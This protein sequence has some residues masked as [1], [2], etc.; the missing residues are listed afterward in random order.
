MYRGTTPTLIFNLSSNP[1]LDLSEVAEVW[2]TLKY[3]TYTKTWERAECSIDTEHKKISV[4]LTQEDT[5]E[6]PVTNKMQAQIRM[7]MNNGSALATNI[8]TLDVSA[9]LK[10]G[11]IE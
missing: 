10:E 3:A 5:L 1:N 4:T 7:L 9:I 11:V 6:M 8:V 2:V